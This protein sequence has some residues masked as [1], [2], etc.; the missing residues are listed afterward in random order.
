MTGHDYFGNPIE[1]KIGQKVNLRNGHR[2]HVHM[3]TGLTSFAVVLPEG[4]APQ[5]GG[6][7]IVGFRCTTQDVVS[8]DLDMAVEAPTEGKTT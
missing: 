8:I 5:V 4:E 1:I 6:I 3:W 2:G 7:Q